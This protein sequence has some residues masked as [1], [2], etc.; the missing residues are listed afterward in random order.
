MPVTEGRARW[1]VYD[2]R[3]RCVAQLLNMADEGEPLEMWD[4]RTYL[5]L[6]IEST[7][8]RNWANGSWRDNP[9]PRPIK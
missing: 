2:E 9:R 7:D 8:E 6:L 4:F 1:E 3:K 5:C